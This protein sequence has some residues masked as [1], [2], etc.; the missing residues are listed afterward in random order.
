MT[1][2]STLTTS[3]TTSASTSQS[4]TPTSSA[5]SSQSTSPTT[6]PSTSATS[7]ATS[8]QTTTATT[9]QVACPLHTHC[10]L[11]WTCSLQFH[12]YHRMLTSVSLLSSYAHGA[13]IWLSSVCLCA[14]EFHRSSRSRR[15]PPRQPRVL[16][17]PKPQQDRVHQ[18]VLRLPLNPPPP[19]LP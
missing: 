7:T 18:R 15:Q 9:S 6:S 8:S 10:L 1:A 14:C 11:P 2:T 5:T 3:Q 17:R 13:L 4:T 19:H 16:H 12:C